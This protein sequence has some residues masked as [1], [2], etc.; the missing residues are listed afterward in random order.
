MLC[1]FFSAILYVQVSL[2]TVVDSIIHCQFQVLKLFDL[3]DLLS[4][5]LKVILCYIISNCIDFD[6]IL[7]N[8]LTLYHVVQSYIPYILYYIEVFNKKSFHI[9]LNIL[10]HMLFH[11]I[12]SYNAEYFNVMQYNITRYN[13]ILYNI[14]IKYFYYDIIIIHF[15]T[16][17]YVILFLLLMSY[18]L[19]IA[20]ALLVKCIHRT[21]IIFV[22][23]LF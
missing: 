3:V 11:Y 10:Q 13:T 8:F 15:Y 2:A 6:R 4:S 5:L 19:P 18:M 14:F 17:I 21:I 16:M 7:L 23:E 12:L 22:I 1:F 20:A 9:Y